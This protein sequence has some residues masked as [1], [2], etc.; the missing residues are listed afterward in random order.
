MTDTSLT[1]IG[2][3]VRIKSQLKAIAHRLL[4]VWRELLGIA[5]FVAMLVSPADP[6]SMF[7][8]TPPILCGMIAVYALACW[9]SAIGID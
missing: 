7:I 8:A 9:R 1:A 5:L 4:C 6:I 2:N 3:D